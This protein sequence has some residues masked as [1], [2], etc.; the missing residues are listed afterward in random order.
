MTDTSRAVQA[1]LLLAATSVLFGCISLFPES[2][3]VQL[4]R[5][6]DTA[7]PLGVATADAPA[8]SVL[9]GA[10]RFNRAA[11]GDRIAEGGCL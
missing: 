11:A 5:F 3:P 6:G 10:T 2:D 8:F 1:C 7:A 9:L 4:Y